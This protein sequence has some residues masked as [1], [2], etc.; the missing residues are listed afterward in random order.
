MLESSEWRYEE[1]NETEEETLDDGDC[2]GK[3]LWLSGVPLTLAL[4]EDVE[5]TSAGDMLKMMCFKMT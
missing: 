2:D 1:D 3:R 5:S 4:E